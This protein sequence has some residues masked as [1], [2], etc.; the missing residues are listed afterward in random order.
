MLKNLIRTRK[1]IRSVGLKISVSFCFFLFVDAKH[2]FAD[3]CCESKS[4]SG[5]SVIKWRSGSDP[6]KFLSFIKDLRMLDRQ[7]NFFLRIEIRL[8]GFAC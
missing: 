6:F 7:T 3:Q 1:R 8:K 4:G 2:F 5:G